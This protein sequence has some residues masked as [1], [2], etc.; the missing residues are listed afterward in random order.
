M[1]L[2][3]DLCL[4]PRADAVP[5]FTGAIVALNA[6]MNEEQRPVATVKGVLVRLSPFSWGAPVPVAPSIL[7]DP[8]Q[9]RVPTSME[10]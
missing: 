7:R 10:A 4:R 2:V 1:T 9:S 5:T 3:V 8:P 6:K